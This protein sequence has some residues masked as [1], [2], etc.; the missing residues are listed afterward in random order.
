MNNDGGKIW[1][2]SKVLDWSALLTFTP[3]ETGTYTF[4]TNY[5]GETCIDTYLY[6]VD[7]NTTNACYYD[8][9]SA[10]DLQALIE[11][12]LVA[13]RTYFIVVSTFNITSIDGILS[14]KISNTAW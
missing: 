8:D 4:R 14:L 1:E 5:D 7:P 11:M 13:I 10:G 3:T 6:V 2:K 9:D 12:D